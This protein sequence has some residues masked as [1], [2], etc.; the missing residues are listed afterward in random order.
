MVHAMNKYQM[1]EAVSKNLMERGFEI[2]LTRGCFEIAAKREKLILLKCLTNVDGLS[3]GQAK[4]LKNISYFLSAYPFIVSIRNNRDSLMD[5]VIYSRFDIPTVTPNMLNDI[6]EEEA[7]S[8]RSSKG[9]HSIDIDTDVLK[10][11]RYELKFSLEELSTLV[12]IS[13]KALYEIENERTSP[14]EETLEKLEYTLDVD[15]KR[16]YDM[17][18]VKRVNVKPVGKLEKRVNME[19]DRIGVENVPV[20]YAPFEIVGKEKFTLITGLTDNT[21]KI[22][23]SASLVKKL[24]KIF[25]SDAFY[26]ARKREEKIIEGLTVLLEEDLPEIESAKELKKIIEENKR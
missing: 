26:V 13:K 17:E 12:G 8:K 23:K 5:D 9:K 3:S 14:V 24:S 6:L 22:V 25:D 10:R 16:A 21:K 7:Y 18:N 1:A 19:L 15:L 4:N 11:R 2:F 20:R